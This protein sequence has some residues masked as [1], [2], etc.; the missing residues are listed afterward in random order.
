[1]SDRL[2][3]LPTEL[4]DRVCDYVCHPR[5]PPELALVCS[6]FV[7]FVRSRRFKDVRTYGSPSLRKLCELF[8][9]SPAAAAHVE[10]L[11][12]VFNI[13][14]DE[15]DGTPSIRTVFRLFQRLTNLVT[16]AIRRSTRLVKALLS[17]TRTPRLLPAIKELILQDRFTG[18]SSPFDPAHFVALSRYKTLFQIEL[19]VSRQASTM[20]ELRSRRRIDLF[21][22]CWVW[23]VTLRGALSEAGAFLFVIPE[24]RSLSL[25]DTSSDASDTIPKLLDSLGWPAALKTLSIN[26]SLTPTA[27]ETLSKA[28][29]DFPELATLEFDDVELTPPVLEALPTLPALKKLYIRSDCTLSGA[30]VKAILLGPLACPTLSFL[31]LNHI[32]WYESYDGEDDF[33]SFTD[34]FT[35]DDMEDVI[36]LADARHVELRGAAVH[37]VREKRRERIEQAEE[38]RVERAEKAASGTGA[39]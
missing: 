10:R 23:D 38:A 33:P 24:V 32:K 21:K 11:E 36:D 25:Y 12:L 26:C 16:L 13:N 39:E 20:N 8:E 19:D 34:S 17:D 30:A 28:L 35:S 7:P 1:M 2:T 14:Y 15:D 6:A 18:W 3:S 4:L 9:A 5:A 27:L 37:W 31:A 29:P 22:T